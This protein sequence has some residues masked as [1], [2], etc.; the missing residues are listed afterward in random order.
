MNRRTIQT[1][2]RGNAFPYDAK[3]EWWGTNPTPPT[4]PVVDWAHSAARGVIADL[5]DRGG[6]KYAFNDIDE[7]IRIEIVQSL[8]EIIRLAHANSA[9]EI[10][11]SENEN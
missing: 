11:R 3:D 6:I 2:S 7:D 10:N 8:A 4:P 1:L 9:A 5:T